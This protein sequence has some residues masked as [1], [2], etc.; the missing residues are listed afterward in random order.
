MHCAWTEMER[1]IYMEKKR[2]QNFW[3]KGHKRGQEQEAEKVQKG[4]K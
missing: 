3:Q 4:H 1:T 2:D